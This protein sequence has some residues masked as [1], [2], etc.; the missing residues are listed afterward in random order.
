VSSTRLQVSSMRLQV[1]S[2]RLQVSCMRLQVSCMWLQVSCMRLQVSCMRLQVSCMR[3][4]VSCMRLQVSCM[5]LQVSCMRLQ[6]SCMRLKRNGSLKANRSLKHVE[7]RHEAR[8][9]VAEPPNGVNEMNAV[10]VMERIAR[11]EECKR[12]S[13]ARQ[14]D[15]AARPNNAYARSSFVRL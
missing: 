7:M 8:G 6:V 4:Q 11:R 1:S 2:M 3:L 9:I 12:T 10:K 14:H 15:E 5:W 13:G